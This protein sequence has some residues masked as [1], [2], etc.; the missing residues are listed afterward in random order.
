MG[1]PGDNKVYEF[2]GF[3]LDAAHLMLYRETDEISLAPKAVQTLLAMVERRGEILSKDELMTAIWTDSIVEESNLAQYLHILRK[4][5]GNQKN[6]K[7]YIETLRRRGYRFNGEVAVSEVVNGQPPDTADGN[8]EP[9]DQIVD[10]DN[11]RQSVNPN[12]RLRRVERHGN[13][14]ALADWNDSDRE[15]SAMVEARLPSAAAADYEGKESKRGRSYLLAIAVAAFLLVSSSVYWLGFGSNKTDSAVRGEVTFLNLTDGIAVEHATIS[16]DGNY[17]AY[18]S[19]DGERSHLW[20]QQTG[21]VNRL[22]ITEPMAGGIYGSSFTPDSQFIY[23]VGAEKGDA[24]HA[25]YRVPTMGGV[26]TRILAD[27]EAPVSFSPDGREMVFMRGSREANSASVIIA[28]SD[29]SHERVLLTKTGDEAESLNGGGAWSPDGTTVA[30]GVVDLKASLEGACSIVG[31]D[32]RS[33]EIKP[34]SKDKWDTCYRMV[35]THDGQGLVFI[36][37][38]AKEA[39]STRR[40]Q[41]YY[42]S[43]PNGDARRLTTDGSRHQ[44]SSLGIT[45]KDEIL[46]VPYNRLSQ[47]WAMDAV[48]DS[49]SVV[50]ITSGQADGR[51]GLVPLSDGRVAYLTRNGDGFSIWLMNADGSGRKQLTTDPPAIEELRAPPDGSFFV[52]SG[53]VDGF[54]HLFRVDANGENLVQLTFGNSNEVDSAVSPDGKWIVYDSLVY[55]SNFGKSALWKIPSG[56]GEPVSM[57]QTDCITPQYSPDG[58]FISCVSTDWKKI[59]MITADIGQALRTFET[60]ENPILNIGAH[61]TP[62]GKALAYLISQN[63]VGNIRLQPI[64]GEAGTSLTDFTSGEI[65]NFGFSVDGSRLFTARGYAIR[66]AVLIKNFR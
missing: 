32:V 5:L 58:Q 14:L 34:L 56:G 45:E 64:N 42:L 8:P 29:G 63:N 23:F 4:T 40:D 18:V 59:S 35:W 22:E 33:G 54:S 62:D 13:V 3:R 41:I 9:S 55:S 2:E 43:L 49:R 50:Q 30:F 51:A 17:F 10:K 7:P 65:Y 66:N 24:P 21:Q 61:W 6:G 39:L 11:S 12:P 26:R 36:G 27:V 31:A 1:K 19:N 16:P 28:A 44:Y 47:I 38:R 52:F 15:Q 20:L 25:L 37:T 53:K 60:A 48:G 57:S 46:A